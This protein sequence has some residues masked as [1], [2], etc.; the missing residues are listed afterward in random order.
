M[1]FIFHKQTTS[2]ISFSLSLS[3]DE[4][5]NSSSRR[6]RDRSTTQGPTPPS[7]WVLFFV[8]GLICS[9]SVRGLICGGFVGRVVMVVVE[10][11]FL[12]C[13]WVEVDGV[14]LNLL[15]WLWVLAVGFCW[16]LI[17]GGVAVGLWDGLLWW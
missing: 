16:G 5:L 10:V 1:S 4:S 9:G 15:A 17:C 12:C 7:S 6:R 14:L 2:A 3:L 8:G 13:W 11:D